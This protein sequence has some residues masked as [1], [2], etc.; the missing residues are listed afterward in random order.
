MPNLVEGIRRELVRC[1]ELLKEYEAMGDDGFFG[2]WMIENGIM[3]GE[4]AIESGEVPRME[5]ALVML[6]AV[7]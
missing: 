3:E 2:R 4:A 5:N 6:A 1:R 7:R